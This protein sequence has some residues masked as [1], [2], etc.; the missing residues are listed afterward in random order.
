MEFLIDKDVSEN[1]ELNK[2]VVIKIKKDEYIFESKKI[3]KISLEEELL[4]IWKNENFKNF[5]ILNDEISEMR[6][7]VY[8]LDILKKNK[9]KNVT[10]SDDPEKKN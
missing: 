2:T 8:I 9:I 5:V 4:K 3:D 10:F 6:T 1:S 7:L